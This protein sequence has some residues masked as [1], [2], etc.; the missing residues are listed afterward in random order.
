M[1]GH[2]L[3]F[4]TTLVLGGCAASGVVGNPQGGVVSPA[5]SSEAQQLAAD[6]HCSRVNKRARLGEALETG[7]IMFDCIW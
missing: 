3:L 5:L 4:L 2:V 1:R 6:G 7:S